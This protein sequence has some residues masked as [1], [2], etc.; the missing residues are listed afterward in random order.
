M[1]LLLRAFLFLL[2]LAIPLQADPIELPKFNFGGGLNV[3]TAPNQINDNQSPDM[4]NMINDQ[5][6]ASIKRNGSKRYIDQA[7]SSNPVNSLYRAYASTRTETRKALFATTWDS[8]YISTSESV[9]NWIR[10][11]SGLKHNQHYGFVTM[12]NKV[13]FTP[14]ESTAVVRQYDFVSSS[15]SN[16]MSADTSNVQVWGKYPLVSRNYFLLG[17]T[18]DL[19]TSCTFYPSRVYYSILA[20]P[21]S[22]TA[23][24]FIDIRTDDGEEITA[25]WEQN[26]RVEIA[27]PSSITELDFTILNLTASGGDQVVTPIVQGFGV[28]APRS[29]ATD[30]ILSI[31]GA[32]DGIRV[33]D[34]GRRTRLTPSDEARVIST[35]IE[36]II[37]ELIRAGTYKSIVGKYYP[38]KRWYV[39]AYEDPKRFPRGKNNSILIYD[40][41]TQ[42]WFPFRN[43]NAES[44]ATFDGAS[45]NG[46]LVFGDSV[47][48]YVYYADLETAYNDARKEIVV[49]PLD[50][51]TTWKRGVVNWS[52]VK[53]GTA[54]IR[55]DLSASVSIASASYVDIINI[56]DWNDKSTISKDDKFSFKVYVASI[57]NVSSIRMDLEINDVTNGEFDANFTSFTISSGAL[58]IGNTSWSTVEF[59]I[60]SFPILSSWVDLVSEQFPFANTFTIYGI[61]FVVEGIGDA[62]VSFDDLRVVQKTEN[63]LNAYRYT[64]QWDF[65]TSADKRFRQ[66]VLNSEKSADSLFYIDVFSNFGELE[67]RISFENTIAKELVVS[68]FGG[69][70]NISLLNSV[71]FSVIDSTVSQA[72]SGFS[73]RPFTAD[74]SFIYGGDQY[75]N[76][77]IKINRSSM[78][79]NVFVSTYGALGSGT[80]NFNLIYQMSQDDNNLYICDLGNHRVKVHRKSNLEFVTAFGTLG[81]NTTSFHNPTGVAVDARNIFVANDG[82]YRI[83]KLNKSTGGFV[84]STLLNLNTIGDT[85]LAVDDMYLYD[86]YNLISPLSL[87]HQDVI[88]E[89]RNKSDLKLVNKITIRPFGVVSISTY[90]LM[91]DISISDDFIYISFTDDANRNG[92]YYIQKRLKSDFSLIKEY[93]SSRSQYAVSFNSFAYK[94]KWKDSFFDL[95]SEGQYIQ[96]RYSD[97]QLDNTMKL[98][99]QGFTTLPT[100]IRER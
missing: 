4:S 52:D 54:S 79:E 51:T 46:E 95:K 96:L 47:D 84:T 50:S 19:T 55:L 45:D 67:R 76:R 88:L 39:M 16:L 24:R 70:E 63:P 82:N 99:L 90:A 30:G 74:Q 6:G 38:K 43:W 41:H 89:K 26:G 85:T 48:G 87:E 40:F 3:K 28:V 1:G 21:S 98:F 56:G 14:Q 31:F 91:G 35:N 7:I 97:D 5:T 10:I 32:Q 64:K 58:L 78:T 75:N 57:Q 11:S 22:M 20:Q 73:I 15:L 61:R 92:H 93:K 59:K 69:S 8:V 66:L 25:I 68:G 9:Q 86:A 53:E 80:T 42:E 49:D 13:I 83:S 36:P 37:N 12:N 18:A 17:N 33:W 81:T 23:L 34:G 62:Y 27:K 77:L 44:L 72:S 60:S 100:N 71:D 65:G 29:L 2:L 94:P